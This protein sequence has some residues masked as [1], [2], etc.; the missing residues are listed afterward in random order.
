MSYLDAALGRAQEVLPR[1][2]PLAVPVQRPSEAQGRTCGLEFVWRCRTPSGTDI[3]MD[4]LALAHARRDP[5][6]SDKGT[7]RALVE[8][9][10]RR[11][12]IILK[13]EPQWY[14][15]AS[16]PKPRPHKPRSEAA[17]LSE[18]PVVPTI[19]DVDVIW[20]V[21]HDQQVLSGSKTWRPWRGGGASEA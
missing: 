9:K 19:L 5:D 15:E 11:R 7:E 2:R 3:I 1:D 10:P 12:A 16:E 14:V 18:K 21:I 20:D 13:Q 4:P 17:K 6:K 8:R